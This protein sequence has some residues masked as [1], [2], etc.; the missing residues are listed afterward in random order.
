MFKILQSRHMCRRAAGS[1]M[2]ES[3]Q[4]YVSLINTSISSTPAA[5]NG[6]LEEHMG[7]ATY[8]YVHLSCLKSI[9]EHLRAY[10]QSVVCLRAAIEQKSSRWMLPGRGFVPRESGAEPVPAGPARPR[11]RPPRHQPCLSK[12]I[13]LPNFLCCVAQASR[14][15]LS[16]P[17]PKLA[18]NRT[19]AAPH[20]HPIQDAA[21][22][23]ERAPQTPTS[24]AHINGPS[25]CGCGGDF[26]R[27]KI[28]INPIKI[29]SY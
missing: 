17:F 9:R 15:V 18:Y 27:D 2:K 3:S 20:P 21:C 1:L 26:W 4:P 24:S 29:T 12:R 22:G 16:V 8:V 28:S 14:C 13:L 6:D 23:K 5:H 10:L 7:P 25:Q 11:P 19:V